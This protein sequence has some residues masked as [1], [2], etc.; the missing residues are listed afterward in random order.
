MSE[1]RNFLFINRLV[2]PLLRASE[3]TLQTDVVF[4]PITVITMLFQ[5]ANKYYVVGIWYI[6]N[7]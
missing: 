3:Y 6:L 2:A 7:A 5:L 4:I 1:Q